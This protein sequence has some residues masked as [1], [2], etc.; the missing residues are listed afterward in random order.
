MAC[1][2][3][4]V[5]T[6]VGMMRELIQDG[7]NGLLFHWDAHELAQKICLLLEDE[8]LRTRLAEAGRQSVQGFHADQV[9]AK[10][11]L[12]YQTLIRRLQER[13]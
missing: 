8:P 13:G 5:T 12:G 1:G 6:P 9:V 3:P 2:I 11:A 7:E 4:A 10:Y